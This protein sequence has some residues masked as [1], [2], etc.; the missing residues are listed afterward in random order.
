MKLYC[1]TW[2][3]SFFY[4]LYKSYLNVYVY[5]VTYHIL[6]YYIK[7]NYLDDIQEVKREFKIHFR[8]AYYLRL[9]ISGQLVQERNV[10]DDGGMEQGVDDMD[11]QNVGW[12]GRK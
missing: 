10:G 9:E 11:G 7:F 4:T 6:I 2:I 12:N 8:I 3:L 1:Y 5:G